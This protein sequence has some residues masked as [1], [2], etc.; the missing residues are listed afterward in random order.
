M[1]QRWQVCTECHAR[2][3]INNIPDRAEIY[4]SQPWRRLVALY[5]ETERGSR[6]E[7]G[8]SSAPRAR[9]QVGME[10]G[11][12]DGQSPRKADSIRQ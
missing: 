3:A 9:S 10:M 1:E 6:L 12:G 11:L 8:R 7:D 2:A 5:C 4:A